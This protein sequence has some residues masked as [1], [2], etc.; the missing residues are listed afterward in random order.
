[1]SPF[2]NVEDVPKHP[3]L[4]MAKKLLDQN[5]L[6]MKGGNAAMPNAERTSI[7]VQTYSPGGAHDPHSHQDREQAFLVLGGKGQIHI[8]DKVYPLEKGSIAYVPRNIRHFT[9]NTS[10]RNLVMMLIDVNLG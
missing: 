1:M 7:I 10:K 8:G 4:A 6:G 3:G 5:V 9:E 2:V